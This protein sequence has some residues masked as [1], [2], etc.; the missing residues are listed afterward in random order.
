MPRRPR[1]GRSFFAPAVSPGRGSSARTHTYLFEAPEG[2][3]AWA[4]SRHTPPSGQGGQTIAGRGV[5]RPAVLR[6]PPQAR[7]YSPGTLE[8]VP[9]AARKA[10]PFPGREAR[11]MTKRVKKQTLK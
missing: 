3:P 4:P 6:A 1:Q 7:G 5:W 8:E 10:G 2:F 9:P 11:G